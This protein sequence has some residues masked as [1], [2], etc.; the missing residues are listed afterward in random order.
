MNLCFLIVFTWEVSTLFEMEFLT[1][2]PKVCMLTGW[3]V[4]GG[5]IVS[6]IANSR[7]ALTLEDT[8][9][10]DGIYVLIIGALAVFVK[11]A[12]FLEYLIIPLILGMSIGTA[13]AAIRK[14]NKISG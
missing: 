1:I 4:F 10:Y 7:R 14:N 8:Q 6:F 11:E 2:V 9:E 3:M 12:A 13:I 5:A